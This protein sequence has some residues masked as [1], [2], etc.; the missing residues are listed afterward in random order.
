M[1]HAM[2]LCEIDEKSLTLEDWNVINETMFCCDNC[3]WWYESSEE[4]LLDGDLMC[5]SCYDDYKDQ[6]EDEE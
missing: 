2:Q 3:G 5:D 4:N 6:E 1:N